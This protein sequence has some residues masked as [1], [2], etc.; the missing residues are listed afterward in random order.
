MKKTG[1]LNHRLSE[2]IATMGHTDLLV[3]ADA[4]LPIPPG[5]ERIDLAVMPGLPPMLDV[6]RAIATELQVERILIASELVDR[7]P[8]LVTAI[9]EI[10]PDLS[11]DHVSHVE[12]KIRSTSAKA[13]VRTGE[14]TPY[15]NVALISGVTF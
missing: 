11:V 8:D 2:V 13:V 15:A 12:F 4:G 5:V 10:F 1:V 14:F 6:L 9:S 7:N 3:V